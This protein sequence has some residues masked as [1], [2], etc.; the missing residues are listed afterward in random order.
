VEVKQFRQ[1]FLIYV[2]DDEISIQEVLREALKDAGYQ[3]QVFPSAEDAFAVIEK[4]PP[5]VILS[6]IRMGGMSGIQLLEKVRVI[7]QDIQFIIM[8]SHASLETALDAMRLGAYDYIHKPFEQID[9]VIKTVD[10]TVEKLYLQ[11]QNEQLL[12]ELAEKNKSLAK[13][14]SQISQEKEEVVKINALMNLF[15]TSKDLDAVIQTM[16]DQCSFL[17]GN[18]PLLFFTHIPSYMSLVISHSAALD[19]ESLKN[20]GVS[21][22]EIDSKEYMNYLHNP[23]HI[24]G[25]KKLIVSGFKVAEYLAI[26]IEDEGTVGGILVVL[27]PINDIPT[28]RLFESFFQIFRVSYQNMRMQ[29]KIH[30]MAIKDPLTGL[31]NRRY[32]NEKLEEEMSRSRRTKMPVSVIYMDIDHFKKYNDANGHPMGDVLLKMYGQILRKTSR[33]NDIVARVGG[34]EFVM[35]LPHTDKMGAAIKAEKLRRVIES[36]PFPHGEKQPLGKVSSSMGVAEYPSH[37]HDAEG[38]VKA[39]DEAL[40]QVKA[41]SRNR[42]CL[43]TSPEDFKMDFEPIKI[44]PFDGKKRDG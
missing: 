41:S 30:D 33:K 34:E 40:Y 31:F 32:F 25:L 9:D 13:L 14:N 16:L 8:T 29:K 26:P 44:E 12:G 21:L 24:E 6:D 5:H 4:N 19:K 43:A 23:M 39:A 22:K 11:F 27:D 10:R 3:V 35:I 15:A 17:I 20:V 18:K 38:L 42:V 1:D 36:T 2:V 28:R 37:C 7:S